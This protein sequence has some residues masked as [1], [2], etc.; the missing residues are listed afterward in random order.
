MQQE[1][2]KLRENLAKLEELTSRLG[3]M[4]NEI[5]KVLGGNDGHNSN[6]S[7]STSNSNTN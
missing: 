5:N 7:S 6:N 1:V 4:L 2:D 3:F